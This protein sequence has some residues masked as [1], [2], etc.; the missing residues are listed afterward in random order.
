ME[1]YSA[2][3]DVDFF[4]VLAS[5]GRLTNY[6]IGVVFFDKAVEGRLLRM[7]GMNSSIHTSLYRFPKSCPTLSFSRS[8][9]SVFSN[10]VV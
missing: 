8:I 5:Y 7:Y 9:V 4:A 2:V 3:T 6:P 1:E 10:L